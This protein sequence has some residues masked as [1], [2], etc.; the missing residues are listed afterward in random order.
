MG[1]INGL[2]P[3]LLYV[4]HQFQDL[5]FIGF[6]FAIAVGEE[7]L[8]VQDD[9]PLPAGQVHPHVI[10][11][12]LQRPVAHGAHGRRAE[13]ATSPAASTYLHNAA[14]G[15]FAIDG[16]GLS[17]NR[18]APNNERDALLANDLSAYLWK[19]AFSF[20]Q[21]NVVHIYVFAHH[22]PGAVAAYYYLWPVLSDER[23]AQ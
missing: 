22:L 17:Q 7:I 21:V 14:D 19:I 1:D 4:G 20:A 16:N 15:S 3:E 11:N 13:G 5:L 8:A 6:A 2:G 10:Q 12:F 23:M 18:F 9:V